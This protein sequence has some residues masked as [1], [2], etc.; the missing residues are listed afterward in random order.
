MGP[1]KAKQIGLST[2]DFVD[3]VYDGDIVQYV[4]KHTPFLLNLTVHGREEGEKKYTLKYE[5]NRDS[6][7]N[8]V[9]IEYFPKSP[10]RQP[11][12]DAYIHLDKWTFIK[13]YMTKWQVI[14]FLN[15]YYDLNIEELYG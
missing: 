4:A 12:S 3:L 6:I 14:D 1:L 7:L 10:P 9:V 11:K 2:Q 13:D 5:D 15:Q 8:G